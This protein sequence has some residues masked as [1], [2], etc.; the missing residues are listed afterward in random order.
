M[1]L[2]S[3]GAVYVMGMGRFFEP[4]K[5]PG[6]DGVGSAIV[7]VSCGAYH[8]GLLTEAGK[9]Y[10]YGTGPSLALPRSHRQ[11]W[12]LAEVTELALDGKAVLGLSCGP[13]TTAMIVAD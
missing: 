1:A 7:G 10:T 8:L 5:V 4:T 2:L 6:T 9:L 13:Y 12:E 11:Q 3:D